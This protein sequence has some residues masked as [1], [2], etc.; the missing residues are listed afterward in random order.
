MPI[1]STKGTFIRMGPASTSAER[2]SWRRN[3][4]GCLNAEV[5]L[6][7]SKR[8]H[9]GG[10]R[11]GAGFVSNL[12]HATAGLLFDLSAQ[13]AV[14]YIGREPGD[15]TFEALLSGAEIRFKFG[16]AFFLAL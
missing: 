9:N 3:R 10:V 14:L 16:D 2:P 1:T 12:D 4:S 5:G 6:G 7:C 11:F 13:S 8:V 15:F